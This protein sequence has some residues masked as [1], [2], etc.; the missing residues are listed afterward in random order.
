[1]EYKVTIEIS[2]VA[3]LNTDNRLV[4]LCSFRYFALDVCCISRHNFLFA[5]Y[6]SLVNKDNNSR[7]STISLVFPHNCFRENTVLTKNLI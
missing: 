3:Y 2:Y 7:L 6:G 1:M 4:F 5:I